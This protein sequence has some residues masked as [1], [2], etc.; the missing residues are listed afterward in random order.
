MA[1]ECAAAAAAA[2]NARNEREKNRIRLLNR[3]FEA[4]RHAVDHR[5]VRIPL[6]SQLVRRLIHLIYLMFMHFMIHISDL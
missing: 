1:S 2:G 6:A 4:L 3:G 5:V